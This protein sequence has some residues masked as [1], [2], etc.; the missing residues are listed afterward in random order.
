MIKDAEEKG[1]LN[2]DSIIIEPTS[3]TIALALWPRPGL[4]ADPDH[5]RHYGIEPEPL[6][7]MALNLC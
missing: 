2:K 3:G 1:L 6:E 7:S 4:Q 5:A